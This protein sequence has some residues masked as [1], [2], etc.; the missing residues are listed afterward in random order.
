MSTLGEALA[1]LAAALLAASDCQ[2]LATE[3]GGSTVG[4]GE[5]TVRPG[6]G[7]F[8]SLSIA[9][10]P[11]S[12]EPASVRVALREPVNRGELVSLFGTPKVLPPST[13]G[14]RTTAFGRVFSSNSATV[15]VLARGK[16]PYGELVLRRDPLLDD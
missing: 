13:R 2:S 10:I 15:T 12:A 9:A 1:T 8:E 16:A 4:A 5:R 7:P 3:L 6:G 11:G 14:Q